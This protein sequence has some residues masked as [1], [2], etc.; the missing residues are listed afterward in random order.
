MSFLRGPCY[1]SLL[2]LSYILHSRWLAPVVLILGS[3]GLPS[4]VPCRLLLGFGPPLFFFVC[5]RS[6][7]SPSVPAAFG[8]LPVCFSAPHFYC[9]SLRCLTALSAVIPLLSFRFASALGLLG[10]FVLRCLCFSWVFSQLSSALRSALRFDYCLYLLLPWAMGIGMHP[11]HLVASA[12]GSLACLPIVTPGSVL[13]SHGC[14]GGTPLIFT[15]PGAVGPFTRTVS[16]R[17]SWAFCLRSCGPAAAPCGPGVRPAVL[18]PFAVADD[19]QS[20]STPLLRAS[21]SRSSPGLLVTPL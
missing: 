15:S 2:P 21:P 14:S 18:P 9:R 20:I 4:F 8:S 17:S 5:L 7:P 1:L 11:L 19:P 13:H 6:S 3:L 16:V 12:A 10:P